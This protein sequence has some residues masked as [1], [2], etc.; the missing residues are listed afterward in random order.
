MGFTNS[1]K[2]TVFIDPIPLQSSPNYTYDLET[3]S[4]R[5]TADSKDPYYYNDS[6]SD[7]LGKPSNTED[8]YV[9]EDDR[10]LTIGLAREIISEL[11]YDILKSIPVIKSSNEW[12][13]Y[14]VA[15][16]LLIVVFK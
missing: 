1:T 12:I 16:L 13:F 10:V 8:E 11:K 2:K 4:Q 15:I 5:S 14:V 7:S 6:H 3:Q 9:D